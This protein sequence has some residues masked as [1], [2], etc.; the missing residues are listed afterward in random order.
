MKAFRSV[1]C[2]VFRE[3]KSDGSKL[4]GS[5]TDLFAL[6]YTKVAST[7]AKYQKVTPIFRWTWRKR[8]MISDDIIIQLLQMECN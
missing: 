5:L 7:V 1:V 3:F 4:N 6:I 2:N 8:N